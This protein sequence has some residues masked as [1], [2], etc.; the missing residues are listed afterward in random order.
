MIKQ[1]KYDRKQFNKWYKDEL[2][3]ILPAKEKGKEAM[4]EKKKLLNQKING[5]KDETGIDDYNEDFLL[6]GSDSFAAAKRRE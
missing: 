3:Q 2:E 1:K 5:A 4:L 6:G